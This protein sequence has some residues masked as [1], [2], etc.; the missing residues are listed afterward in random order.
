[1]ADGNLNQLDQ[2][3]FGKLMQDGFLVKEPFFDSKVEYV[4]FKRIT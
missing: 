1:M 3:D 2:I 4:L